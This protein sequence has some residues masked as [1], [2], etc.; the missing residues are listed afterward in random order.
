M[1]GCEYSRR[2][3]EANLPEAREH[4]RNAP[5]FRQAGE[6]RSLKRILV[7]VDF[8]KRSWLGIRYALQLAGGE[9]ELILL[10]V[11]DLALNWPE[12]GPVNVPRL[13]QEMRLEAEKKMTALVAAL[14]PQ[15]VPLQPVITRGLVWEATTACARELGVNLIIVGQRAKKSWSIYHRHMARRIAEQAPC[16]VLRV[17]EESTA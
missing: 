4:R 12:T 9:G 13:E 7:P 14:R 16:P 8:S 15:G 3:L 10:H 11:I 6:G 2:G 5:V 17:P 1:N